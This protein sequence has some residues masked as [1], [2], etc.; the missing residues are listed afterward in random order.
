[1]ATVSAFCF[2]G[3]AS[4][5]QT[6]PIVLQR[7]G[8]KRRAHDLQAK[9][10]RGRSD[11]RAAGGAAAAD[12]PSLQNC[13]ALCQRRCTRGRIVVVSC[14]RAPGP[15]RCDCAC[16]APR[17]VDDAGPAMAGGWDA[18]DGAGRLLAGPC[19]GRTVDIKEGGGAED[20]GSEPARG[21]RGAGILGALSRE[22]GLRVLVMY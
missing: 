1:M 6:P 21:A 17:Y 4:E 12:I 19:P 14:C 10:G 7:T 8:C 15:W 22:L 20:V 11:G 9:L 3:G 2:S 5:P 16:Y 18:K 13:R